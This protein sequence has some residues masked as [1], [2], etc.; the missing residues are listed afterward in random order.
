MTY[1]PGRFSL[2]MLRAFDVT[3]NAEYR[4]AGLESLD[5]LLKVCFSPDGKQLLP[6]WQ[7]RLVSRRW[8]TR[9]I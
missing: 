6:D 8:N 9:A 7:P 3:T 1:D 5:F 4:E 2:A